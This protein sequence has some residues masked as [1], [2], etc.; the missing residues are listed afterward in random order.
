MRISKKKKNTIKECILN[1]WALLSIKKINANKIK[2]RGRLVH[3]FRHLVTLEVDFSDF[4]ID[5]KKK[6]IEILV[7]NTRSCFIFI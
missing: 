4:K 7:M 6:V 2:G 3:G 1:Y 5:L